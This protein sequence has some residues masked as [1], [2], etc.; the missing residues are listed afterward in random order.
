MPADVHRV[1]TSAQWAPIFDFNQTMDWV[2]PLGV[3]IPYEQ[4]ST[5][6]GTVLRK[7]PSVFSLAPSLARSRSG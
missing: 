1:Y 5:V 4:L 7:I 2:Q 3:L 6:L